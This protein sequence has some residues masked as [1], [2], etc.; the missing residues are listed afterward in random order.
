MHHAREL[1]GI[2]TD[3]STVPYSLCFVNI[4]VLAPVVQKVDSAIHKTNHRAPIQC[5]CVSCC[6]SVVNVLDLLF[7]SPVAIYR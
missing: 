2:K 7:A 1:T 6:Y 5:V 3:A 4:V